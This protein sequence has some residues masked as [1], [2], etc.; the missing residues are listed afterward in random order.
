M[1]PKVLILR[2]AGTNCDYETDHAFQL[3]GGATSLIHVNQL[4]AGEVDLMDYQIMAIPGGFSYGDDV[5]AGILLAN[6]M[7]YKLADSLST[8]VESGR[9]DDRYLQWVSGACARWPVTAPRFTGGATD[10]PRYEHVRKV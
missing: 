7:R 4:I 9:L 6:E 1:K 3:V 10:N 8:Y 5:A 2:T